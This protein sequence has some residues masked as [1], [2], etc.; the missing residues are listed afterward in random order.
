MK[1]QQKHESKQTSFSS[2]EVHTGQHGL[3]C[4]ECAKYVENIMSESD[5]E[6]D[7]FELES[8]ELDA[9]FEDLEADQMIEERIEKELKMNN[10]KSVER[11]VFEDEVFF[12]GD[13]KYFEE[14]E[15]IA[16]LQFDE[17]LKSFVSLN[18]SDACF[19]WSRYQEIE[20]DRKFTDI[21]ELDLSADINLFRKNIHDLIESMTKE[22]RN[23]KHIHHFIK[24][25][26][27]AL[28]FIDSSNAD[29]YEVYS[30]SAIHEQLEKLG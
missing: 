8:D 4:E 10:E 2:S 6:P 26:K 7:S 30:E 9:Q 12:E 22:S 24:D 11:F 23:W 16:K 1:N 29:L 28:E 3:D 17:E 20:K 27:F 19:D 18:R 5:N 14:V 15:G 13:E 25:A 21:D